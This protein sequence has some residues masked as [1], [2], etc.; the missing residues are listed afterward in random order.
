MNA[1]NIKNCLGLL[2]DQGYD[3]ALSMEC[4]GQGRPMIERSWKWLRG[5]LAELSI[6]VAR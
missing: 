5:T 1:E 3:G 2:R 4:E 6:P